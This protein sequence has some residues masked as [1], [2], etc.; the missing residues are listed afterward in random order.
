MTC[1]IILQSFA[2][3]GALNPV[4][5]E[6][7]LRNRIGDFG[8]PQCFSISSRRHPHGSCRYVIGFIFLLWELLSSDNHSEIFGVNDRLRSLEIGKEEM[9]FVAD[10][11]PFEAATTIHHVFIAGYEITMESRHAPTLRVV[12]ATKRRPA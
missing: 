7:K 11:G 12:S 1:S 8:G 9:F 2:S 3:N 10:G 5:M 4:S 6:A